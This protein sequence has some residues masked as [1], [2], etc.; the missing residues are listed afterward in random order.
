MLLSKFKSHNFWLI[1]PSASKSWFLFPLLYT[2]FIQILT[3]IPK[4]SILRERSAD[5]MLLQ[6]AEEIFD[7]PYWLQDISHL[8][9]FFLFA[10]L[11]SWFFQR[12][13]DDSAIHI[14]SAYF[15]IFVIRYLQRTSTVF[16]STAISFFRRLSHE[17]NGRNFRP[18]PPPQGVQKSISQTSLIMPG[19]VQEWWDENDET[20]PVKG[21]VTGNLNFQHIIF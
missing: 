21:A 10:W 19:P 6:F 2:L 17:S 14:L 15:S 3:G 7:Y 1:A 18:D 8:P 5:D 13:K 11:W 4:P 9:L 20:M 12:K 16:Y